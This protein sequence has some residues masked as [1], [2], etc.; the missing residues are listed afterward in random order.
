MREL[1][2][3]RSEEGEGQGEEGVSEHIHMLREYFETLANNGAK[4]DA[5]EG[6]KELLHELTPIQG[7]PV[8][9][10]RWVPLD[11]V[12][13]NTWNP[14]SVATNEMRLL[15]LSISQDGYTQPIVTIHDKERDRYVVVD[16]FHRFTTM[17]LNAD[18]AEKTGG[19]VPVVVIDKPVNELMAS[20]VRHNRA[21]GRHAVDGMADMVFSMLENGWDDEAVCAQLGL[22]AD[23]LLRLKHV[24]GFS[25]LFENME[26]K[27]K[28][29]T[30][31]QIKARKAYRD[32]V[33]AGEAE[34]DAVLIEDGDQEVFED[35][36][37]AVAGPAPGSA[38]TSDEEE[39][40]DVG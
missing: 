11:K 7:M 6:I 20:T 25:K 29:E 23:E 1:R 31:N 19:R 28:W 14:N 10:V 13:A 3:D 15:Y 36:I 4:V 34:A 22:S 27:R 2:G 16:G 12:E 26:F 9:R 32:K 8:D 30:R 18:L 38:P 21:R 35:T 17:R 5:I 39:A 37:E 40:T 33:A 24:T